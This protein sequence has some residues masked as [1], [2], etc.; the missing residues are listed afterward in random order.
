[1]NKLRKFWLLEPWERRL[2]IQSL[3]VLAVTGAALRLVSFKR[4]Q[5][6]LARIPPIKPAY[7]Q[8]LVEMV[9]GRARATSRLVCAA[10]W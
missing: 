4:W 1:M 6:I 8:Q 10:A 5:S 7:D 2:F 9:A 3:L